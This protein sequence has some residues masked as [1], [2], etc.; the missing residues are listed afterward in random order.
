MIN[1]STVTAG[2]GGSVLPLPAPLPVATMLPTQ[3]SQPTSSG[4]TH[5]HTQST[6]PHGPIIIYLR[7]SNTGVGVTLLTMVPSLA[8]LKNNEICSISHESHSSLASIRT[9]NGITFLQLTR[10]VEVHGIYDFEV[11]CVP[12]NEDPQ[13]S[14]LELSKS[15]VILKLHII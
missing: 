3:L 2:M 7:R 9:E 13:V 6:R 1:V 5:S 8:A 12:I 10:Q 11:T 15:S 14:G 4:D